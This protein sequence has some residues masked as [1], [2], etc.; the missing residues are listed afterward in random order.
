MARQ[1]GNDLDGIRRM[2]VMMTMTIIMMN[3][4]DDDDDNDKSNSTTKICLTLNM[5]LR[6][7]VG[8]APN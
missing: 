4:D 1:S 6:S 8:R 5:W 3:D 2:M 7:S